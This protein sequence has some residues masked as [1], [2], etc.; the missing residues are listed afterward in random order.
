MAK[1]KTYETGDLII[2]IDESKCISCGTCVALAPKTFELDKK[3]MSV[4]KP[5][6]NDSAKVI[7]EAAQSC[8]V[9]AI[10]IKEKKTGKKLN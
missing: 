6:P 3:L 4:V 7:I 9:E 8:A 1:I 2:E 10:T 5:G